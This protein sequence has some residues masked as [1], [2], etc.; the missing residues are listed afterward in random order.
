VSDI[1]K[2]KDLWK[3]AFTP[4]SV[5][6]IPHSNARPWNFKIPFIGI[7][8]SMVLWLF[9]TLYVFSVAVDSFEYQVMKKELG[10]YSKQFLELK[11]T[12]STLRNAEREFKSLLSH[13]TKEEILENIDTS[14]VGSLDMESLRQQ[15]Q[16]TIETV[17]GIKDYLR[18]QRDL[19]LA[20]PKGLPVE[21]SITSRY[22][23][24]QHPRSGEI[25]FHTGL[26]ISAPPSSPVRA[27]ADGVV[28]FSGW[29]GGSGNLV[30]LE[31]GFGFSTFYAH[32]SINTVKV[33]QK[34]KRGEIIG[35][36]GSTGNA[37][38]PHVHYEVCK[39]GRSV[40]PSRYIKG[41]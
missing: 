26:D 21:G 3:K 10:Y 34:V 12:I 22:G 27:T 16:E 35:Y 29:N 32:N 19:Y 37:T 24:R 25:D 31:H 6:L 1:H 33:G 14:D 38:G 36:V 11:T 20:T 4:V 17:S 8:V 5:M 15:I 7:F 30:V 39:N 28:S 2:I 23:E 41:R 18:H 13:G 9:G 40:N